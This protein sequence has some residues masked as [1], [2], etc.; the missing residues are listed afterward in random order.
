MFSVH[1][2][3]VTM[4]ALHAHAHK[5]NQRYAHKCTA[6]YQSKLALVGIKVD[7]K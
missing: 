3:R 6:S 5:D 1:V 4:R 2:P 7:G